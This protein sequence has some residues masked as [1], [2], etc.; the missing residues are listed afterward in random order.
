MLIEQFKKVT[1]V[2]N[3]TNKV[4][5]VVFDMLYSAQRPFT[6]TNSLTDKPVLV[7]KKTNIS[8]I[9]QKSH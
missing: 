3:Y 4:L 7:A 6:I 2:S 5:N 1:S 9:S 8:Y